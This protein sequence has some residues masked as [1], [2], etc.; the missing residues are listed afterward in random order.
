MST[1]EKVRPPRT[2]SPQSGPHIWPGIAVAAGG[3]AVAMGTNR[4]VPALSALTV[5]VL[6]GVLVGGALPAAASHGLQWATRAF[7]RAGVVLLGLQLSLG[8]VLHLGP[9]MLA[10]VTVTVLTG[11]TGT[12]ALARL[13]GVSRGLG[14]MVATGFSI[15]GASAIVAMDSVARSK[16]EDVATAVTLVTI[17]GGAAIAVVPFLGTRVFGLDPETLGMWAGLSVHEVAQVVAAASPAGAAAVGTAVIVKLTRVVLL[18]PMVAGMGVVERKAGGAAGGKRPPIVPLFVAGF[19]VMLL[20]RSADVV[21]GPV[22]TG[23]KELST[24]LLAAAMFGLGTSVRI[25]SLLRTG[26]RGLLLGALSTLLVG[27]VSLLALTVLGHH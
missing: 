14:L 5:A 26:R 16:K 13:L 17:Y 25:R 21:P 15:C 12:L 18:A 11:F 8:E 24:V 19:L 7:L 3:A 9:G 2:R 4:L 10:V 6:L 23:A 20:L 27:T 22:L 1:L